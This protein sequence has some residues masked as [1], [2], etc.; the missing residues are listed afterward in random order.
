MVLLCYRHH[1]LIHEG[2][3]QLVRSAE[4]GMLAI[5]PTPIF[6][7]WTRAPVGSG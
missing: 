3:W 6:R 5:A 7:T 2:G 4:G 1:W